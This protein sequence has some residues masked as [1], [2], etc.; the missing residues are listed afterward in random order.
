MLEE[1]SPPTLHKVSINITGAMPEALQPTCY[2]YTLQV[3]S[4]PPTAEIASRS[5]FGAAYALEG[6]TQ[7]LAK[8]GGARLPHGTISVRDAPAYASRPHESGLIPAQ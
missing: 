2:N 1:D 5:V 7:L 6:L 4:S 8:G 3:R